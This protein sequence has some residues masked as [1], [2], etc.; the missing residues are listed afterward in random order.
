MDDLRIQDEYKG[1][2][3]PAPEPVFDTLPSTLHVEATT[4]CN[5]RCRMCVKHTDG[6]GIAEGDLSPQV[7]EALLPV[8]PVV[9]RLLLNGIGEP[10]LH[11]HDR[12]RRGHAA[13]GRLRS[14]YRYGSGLFRRSLPEGR[15][16]RN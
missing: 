3:G 12:V 16:R 10:L 6:G 8:L 1:S 11:P 7:F 14:G 15:R 9:D 13:P 2:S 4:R 5:L